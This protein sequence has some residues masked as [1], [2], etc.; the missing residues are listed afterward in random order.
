M[1]NVLYHLA[2]N[3]RDVR[4]IEFE[5]AILNLSSFEMKYEPQ[6]V[7]LRPYNIDKNMVNMMVNRSIRRRSMVNRNHLNKTIEFIEQK[8]IDG[9]IPLF[10]YIISFTIDEMKKI[11]QQ[12][13]EIRIYD[14]KRSSSDWSPYLSFKIFDDSISGNGILSWNN[15]FDMPD[16]SSTRYIEFREKGRVVFKSELHDFIDQ[17]FVDKI[18]HH[19][20]QLGPLDLHIMNYI[21]AHGVSFFV[22][23]YIKYLFDWKQIIGPYQVPGFLSFK[24]EEE[25]EEEVLKISD[26]RKSFKLKNYNENFLKLELKRLPAKS[27]ILFYLK[28]GMLEWQIVKGQSLVS[29]KLNLSTGAKFL[30]VLQKEKKRAKKAQV[31]VYG[32]IESIAQALSFLLGEYYDKGFLYKLAAT[33][34]ENYLQ[35]IYKPILTTASVI[36]I[37]ICK[38]RKRKASSY[39]SIS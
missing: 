7:I 20:K 29:N 22:M 35:M 27:L 2:E 5:R 36:Y 34:F 32:D 30:F 4:L 8:G 24:M 1:A 12:Y 39:C 11:S 31:L 37:F 13:D 9:L 14:N 23:N 15:D 26:G 3:L 18:K 28:N 33:F 10:S 16:E 17:F 38:W 21:A 6:H 19:I 25:E